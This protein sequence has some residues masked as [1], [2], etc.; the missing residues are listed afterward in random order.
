MLRTFL[1]LSSSMEW[2]PLVMWNLIYTRITEP[3]W[4]L[5]ISACS[6]QFDGMKQRMSHF[7]LMHQINFW[8]YEE[9]GAQLKTYYFVPYWLYVVN[10]TQYVTFSH[11][12]NR[13]S[14][15]G[16]FSQRIKTSPK[17]QSHCSDNDN[18]AK[19]THS[20]GWM[21]VCVFRRD[22]FNQCLSQEFGKWECKLKKWERNLNSQPKKT[23][24]VSTALTPK[25][26]KHWNPKKF[27]CFKQTLQRTNDVKKG[28]K[29]VMFAA[30]ELGKTAE[31]IYKANADW[32]GKRYT[33]PRVT[34]L[35]I[36]TS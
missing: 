22:R 32:C 3:A 21:S 13:L 25:T 19:R 14:A 8:Y 17:A 33:V 2:A 24:I 10:T 30:V 6:K 1:C 5:I 18:D 7:M 35:P 20:I 15:L 26:C 12:A 23:N 34:Q 9:K 36:L 31:P 28:K 11:M 16:W 29:I 27:W 4:I